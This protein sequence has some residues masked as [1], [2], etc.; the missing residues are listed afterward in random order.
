MKILKIL[1]VAIC[2]T[3]LA[4]VPA[5]ASGFAAGIESSFNTTKHDDHGYGFRLTGAYRVD[6][7]KRIWLMPEIGAGVCHIIQED[8]APGIPIYK[9]P[10]ETC[11][12]GS[13]S[14]L[15]GINIWRGLEAFT[16]PKLS[17]TPGGSFFDTTSQI[18]R[19][20]LGLRIRR[21][22]ISASIDL[23]T[24]SRFSESTPYEWTIGARYYF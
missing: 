12:D 8:F 13:V 2:M 1:A 21:I 23:F 17:I 19:F 10:K 5:Q 6:L 7:T 15:A 14:L 18:W 24:K 11:F 20:G 9:F 16:G 3:F 4:A 22:G